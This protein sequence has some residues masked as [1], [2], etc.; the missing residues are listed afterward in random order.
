P[1]TSAA[2]Y[3]TR[4]QSSAVFFSFQQGLQA[5]L[6]VLTQVLCCRLTQ[7]SLAAAKQYDQKY[8]PAEQQYSRGKPQ[9]HCCR[10]QGRLVTHKVTIAADH[11][12]ENLSIIAALDDHAVYFT[13]QVGG[14]GGV[15]IG[16][17]LILTL[18]AAQF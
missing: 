3:T 6:L 1:P 13:A 2:R 17:I 7:R 8:K 18:G 15:G 9:H 14:D 16:N 11:E 5:L 10:C 12:V 4:N